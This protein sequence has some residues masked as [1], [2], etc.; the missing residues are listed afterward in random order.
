MVGAK[1]KRRIRAAM[2]MCCLIAA[3]LVY[4]YLF[5]DTQ[6][7]KDLSAQEMALRQQFIATAEKWLGCKEEDGSHKAIIDLYNS[8]TPLAQ[9]YSVK[10]TDSWCA[11]FVSAVAIQCGLTDI[12]PT[13][14]G[15]QRQI[16]LLK[17]LGCWQEDDDYIPSPG[18]LIYYS[19]KGAKTFGEN[20]GW[21]DHVGIV[22]S[23]Q[24]RYIT[25]IEGNY[26]DEVT[27]R[28]ILVGD[29]KIRGYGLPDFAAKTD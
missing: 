16:E 11:T 13:E 3:A 14:C 23:V 15:C 10:Y 24:G 27:Y 6:P 21:S 5:L 29:P 18:D 26:H 17:K 4:S 28:H 9:G 8:H 12:I 7:A 25:T 19:G 1:R 2:V 20:E 22:V